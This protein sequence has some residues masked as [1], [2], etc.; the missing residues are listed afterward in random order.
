MKKITLL[1]FYFFTI[2]ITAQTQDLI[3]LSAGKMLNFSALYKPEYNKN[4]VVGN[5]LWGYY[6]IYD[7]GKTEQNTVK[8]ELIFFDKNLNKF[9]NLEFTQ[10]FD[11]N[12]FLRYRVSI[13]LDSE[14]KLLTQFSDEFNV[15]NVIDLDKSEIGNPFVYVFGQRKELKPSKNNFKTLTKDYLKMFP[16]KSNLYVKNDFTTYVYED[17]DH[18]YKKHHKGLGKYDDD[19]YSVTT[20][21]YCQTKDSTKLWEIEV[22]K[23]FDAKKDEYSNNELS[24]LGIKDDNYFY[25]M[26]LS[27]ATSSYIIKGIKVV[28]K[29]SGK[30]VYE[31]NNLHTKSENLLDYKIIANHQLVI[32]EGTPNTNKNDG[33]YKKIIINLD[34]NGK[35]ISETH[36]Q[37]LDAKDY[38]TLDKR[39]KLDDKFKLGQRDFTIHEDGSV[40]MLF[41]KYKDAKNPLNALSIIPIA[42]IIANMATQSPYKTEDFLIFNFDSNFK[43]KEVKII[44]KDISKSDYTDF[45]FSQY[46]ENGLGSVYFYSDLRKDEI[47]KEKIWILGIVSVIKGKINIEEFPIISKENTIV[48]YVAKDGYIILREYNEKEKYNQIRLEKLNY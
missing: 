39:G 1:I 6:A 36:F 13:N 4:G 35:N 26:I 3:N 40:V 24:D 19:S 14:V 20:M 46:I 31:T 2:S 18:Y 7:L 27:K 16:D 42:G 15:Y 38:I 47:T 29:T 37:F 22:N 8:R 12:K 34:D 33:L 5:K 25:F 30:V 28:D 9:R 23:L 11:K 10:I 32:L 45:L 43:L 41:E 21:E 17:K 48:P 44:N